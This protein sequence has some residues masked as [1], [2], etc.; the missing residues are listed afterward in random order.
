M[1]YTLTER[2][3]TVFKRFME[4]NKPY[5]ESRMRK[6]NEE[7]SIMERERLEQHP[8]H[9]KHTDWIIEIHFYEDRH[10]D[11]DSDD[12]EY[13]DVTASF[14]V[15]LSKDKRE[16]TLFVKDLSEYKPEQIDALVKTHRACRDCGDWELVEDTWFCRDCY[17]FVMTREEDCCCCLDHSEGKWIKLSCQHILHKRCWLNIE[18]TC[19]CHPHRYTRKCPLCR[20]ESTFPDI[21][22]V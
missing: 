21:E 8:F 18:T 22:D 7:K 11:D 13:V 1:E 5:A 9:A 20:K 19:T 2:T 10:Y 6:T 16:R 17:P 14:R 15:Y 4:A 12:E 3:A